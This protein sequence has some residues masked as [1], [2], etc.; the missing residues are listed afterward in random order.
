VNLSQLTTNHHG[1]VFAE[2][3]KGFL[4]ARVQL[5]TGLPGLIL[6]GHQG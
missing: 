1:L 2:T 5:V 6:T 3:E 4:S